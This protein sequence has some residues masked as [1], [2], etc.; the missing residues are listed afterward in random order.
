[1]QELLEV[2]GRQYD[3]VLIDSPPVLF[4]AD[5]SILGALC[6]GVLLVVKSARNTLSLAR[7]AR[8]HLDG[9]NARILGGVL[10][11][12]HVARLGPHYS[13]YYQYGYARYY[14][15]YADHYYGAEGEGKS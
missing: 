2:A 6:D 15:D 11:D 12:V 13:D 10:N 5:A 7:R 1:M 8:Q 9:V 3:R 4:V 14:E